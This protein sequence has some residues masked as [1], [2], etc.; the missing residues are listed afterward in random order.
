MTAT[1]FETVLAADNWPSAVRCFNNNVPQRRGGVFPV[2]RLTDLNWYAHPTEV[3]AFYLCHL[4]YSQPDSDL[5]ARLQSL[6]LLDFLSRLRAL[7]DEFNGRLKALS[8]S[9]TYRSAIDKVGPKVFSLALTRNTLKHL[10]LS[11][12]RK[13]QLSRIHLAWTFEYE[14]LSPSPRRDDEN[15]SHD[16][17]KQHVDA[18]EADWAVYIAP[19]VEAANATARGQHRNNPRRMARLV[20]FL[21][22]SPARHLYNTWVE[23]RARR[24]AIREHYCRIVSEDIRAMYTEGRRVHVILGGPPCTGFSRIGRAVIRE[25]RSQGAHAW[26]SDRF[27]DQRN[28]LMLKYVLFLEALEPD[29][30]LFEN[31]ANFRSRLKT[32]DGT[33]DGSE[34]LT[35]II[36]DVSDDKLEYHVSSTVFACRHHGIPQARDRYI[37]CGLRANKAKPALA[38]RVLNIKTYQEEVPLL[39][40][41]IG[42]GDPGEFK[43]GFKSVDTSFR[44]SAFTLVDPRQPPAVVGYV[45][46]VR[47]VDPS[48][49]RRPQDTDAHIFRNPRPD[50]A[51]FFKFVAPGIRWMDLTIQDGPTLRRVRDSGIPEADRSLLLRLLLESISESQGCQHH[52][53]KSGYLRNGTGTHG[54]WLE[55]LSA[56]K[57]SRTIVAHI[58]KDTYAYIHPIEP[59]PITIREAAR[60]Q[61]FP[62]FFSFSGVG[63][64]DAYSMIGNAVPPLLAR[65]LAASLLAA[66]QV[67]HLFS[68][69]DLPDSDV[70]RPLPASDRASQLALAL[71]R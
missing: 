45:N 54:D 37:L 19:L 20:Q 49:G 63:I 12:L 35:Q 32:R 69:V 22:S 52:L 1:P 15:V 55:R 10:G 46:W 18:S 70:A 26:P 64:V 47:Q 57:P 60:I 43:F 25:L 13:L 28:A 17:L 29:A 58:G 6:G 68:P 59:R 24:I 21:E 5:Q 7:D 31:V 42:L 11:S 40:A 51:E 33:L 39:Y 14:T 67:S 8:A 9:D 4:A 38:S 56:H 71:P 62:D 27:G 66:S 3:L 50:D 16:E 2:G 23:W 48:T 53:L 44:T 36:A 65:H 34:L 30:F 61:S 41:M